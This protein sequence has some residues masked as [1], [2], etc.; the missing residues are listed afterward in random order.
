MDAI[1]GVMFMP[2]DQTRNTIEKL[3]IVDIYRLTELFSVITG[4]KPRIVNYLIENINLSDN[5]VSSTIQ[6]MADYTG[7]S[8]KTIAQTLQKL[9]D[10]NIIRRRVG[11]VMINPLILYKGNLQKQDE[12]I[13]KFNSFK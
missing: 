4:A 11:V 8:T 5:V 9:E 1:K 12:L 6:E 7:I 13:E 10:A 2:S 3:V